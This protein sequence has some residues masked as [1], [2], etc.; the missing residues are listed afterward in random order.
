MT[1]FVES[2]AIAFAAFLVF[3][4]IRHATAGGDPRGTCGPPRSG[5]HGDRRP[6]PSPSSWC[7]PTAA[8]RTRSTRR[9]RRSSRPLPPRSAR[10]ARRHREPALVG[11]RGDRRPDPQLAPGSP[12]SCRPILAGG[13]CVFLLARGG[14]QWYVRTARRGRARAAPRL[15]AARDP[16]DLPGPEIDAWLPTARASSGPIRS[17]SWPSA[18]SSSRSGSSATAGRCASL[19]AGLPRPRS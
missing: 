5:P 4:E 12:I 6:S 16:P 17:P 7:A 18:S 8:G 19:S 11:R 3:F 10:R 15:H 13:A 14:P 2:L 1:R 9:P